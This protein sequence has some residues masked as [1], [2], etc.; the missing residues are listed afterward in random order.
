MGKKGDCNGLISRAEKRKVAK[1]VQKALMDKKK[2]LGS[3][4]RKVKW[5]EGCAEGTFCRPYWLPK[6]WLHGVKIGTCGYS[7]AGL[8]VY[9]TPEGKKFYHKVDAEKHVGRKLTIADGEP[10]TVE[11]VLPNV[12]QRIPSLCCNSDERLFAQLDPTER[13]QLPSAREFHFCIISARR[14]A[15]A[16]GMRD[17][18][19]VQAHFDAAGIKPRWYVD[20]PSLERYRRMG[21]DAVK[22]GGGLVAARNKALDDAAKSKKVCCQVSDDI[23]RWHYSTAPQIHSKSLDIANAVGRRAKKFQVSPV[24]AAR[25]LIAKMRAHSSQPKLGGVLPTTNIAMALHLPMSSH[26]N[27][28]LGDFF[29][30]EPQSRVRFDPKMTLKED[31][32]FTCAHLAKYRTV[33]RCNR[34]WLSV[35]HRTNAGGAVTVRNS[36]EEQR[37]I[38][39]LRRKWPKRIRLHHTKQDEVVINSGRKR[40]L[41]DDID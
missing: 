6:G 28:I 16:Q 21:L 31:Y 4:A 8:R 25:F 40:S 36:E 2:I 5:P 3:K 30:S 23:R 37:N 39:I 13:S 10:A 26:T 1:R 27:F 34:L 9:I 7:G 35:K 15:T 29:V 12:L 14:T 41:D 18:L 11:E 19:T 33:L 38:K 20:P 32:D 24:A 17:C 22:D